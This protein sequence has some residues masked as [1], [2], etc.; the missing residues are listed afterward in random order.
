MET[1]AYGIAAVIIV[2]SFL[3]GKKLFSDIAQKK[4]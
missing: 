3:F 2:A 4:I 1:L